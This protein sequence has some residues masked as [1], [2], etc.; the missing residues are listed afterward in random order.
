MSPIAAVSDQD[1][2]PL[3]QDRRS[4]E[5]SP[6]TLK[7]DPTASSAFSRGTGRS[8]GSSARSRNIWWQGGSLTG[9]EPLSVECS[10]TVGWFHPL[11]ERKAVKETYETSPSAW[12]FAEPHKVHFLDPCGLRRRA[13][14]VGPCEAR[15]RPVLA[16][17][18]AG[19]TA[20]TA[21]SARPQV[22]VEQAGL[23]RQSKA[24]P[25]PAQ[26]TSATAPQLRVT[27]RQSRK[28]QCEVINLEQIHSASD[29]ESDSPGE[30]YS[31]R[32]RGAGRMSIAR[33]ITLASA[34]CS[35][36]LAARQDSEDESR[37]GSQDRSRDSPHHHSEVEVLETTNVL[38]GARSML[39]MQAAE[40]RQTRTNGARITMCEGAILMDKLA[41]DEDDAESDVEEQM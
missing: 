30:S 14:R 11:P 28:S 31:R 38:L 21:T 2:E 16:S 3:P 27:I 40:A 36:E 5:G 24:E 26:R 9:V 15:R 25:S 33:S 1:P 18:A 19:P 32:G 6:R 23:K 4:D 17:L 10:A 12:R 34:R 29:S 37:D 20:S 22:S 35:V 41:S 13:L 7:R 39:A 8:R